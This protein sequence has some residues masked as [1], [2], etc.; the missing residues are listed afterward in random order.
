MEEGLSFLNA[1]I[2]P[3]EEVFMQSTSWSRPSVGYQT[4]REMKGHTYHF[5]KISN[6][7]DVS[8]VFEPTSG[9]CECCNRNNEMHV[10]IGTKT[11]IADLIDDCLQNVSPPNSSYFGSSENNSYTTSNMGYNLK[12]HH[13]SKGNLQFS[14]LNSVNFFALHNPFWV[15]SCLG[16]NDIIDES[17]SAAFHSELSR[18]FCLEKHEYFKFSIAINVQVLNGDKKSVILP[19]SG[20]KSLFGEQPE[21]NYEQYTKAFQKDFSNYQST[22]CPLEL[23]EALYD[24][25]NYSFETLN[26]YNGK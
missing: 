22:Q 21:A 24:H 3:N 7:Y 10:P 2:S 8:I 9:N 15:I 12:F 6:K 23:F 14:N 20:F 11:L 18:L 13:L 1:T 5:G 19:E 26:W 25:P 17:S 16:Q 4:L